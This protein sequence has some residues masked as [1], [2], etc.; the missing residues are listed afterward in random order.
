M[1]IDRFTHGMVY[2]KSPGPE[3]QAQLDKLKKFNKAITVRV[4]VG[5]DRIFE[6]KIVSILYV[7]NLETTDHPILKLIKH[8]MNNDILIKP[9]IESMLKS[10]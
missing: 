6:E 2:V 1:C 7:K 8:L 10:E 4:V 3:R 5:N 9:K